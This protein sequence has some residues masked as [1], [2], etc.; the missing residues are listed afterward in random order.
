MMI[1]NVVGIDTARVSTHDNVRVDKISRIK[2]ET[3]SMSY[4]LHIIQE[5]PELNG[6][7][8]FQPSAKLI[9]HVMDAILLKKLVD[10]VTVSRTVQKNP[11][12]VIS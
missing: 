1:G 8:R 4:F 11:G 9:L 10:P 6:C 2:C 3:N 7:R 5:Y 12:R